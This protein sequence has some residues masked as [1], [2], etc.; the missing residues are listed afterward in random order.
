M[1]EALLL[2]AK[3]ALIDGELQQAQTYLTE[4]KTVATELNRSLL[5]ARVETE[6]TQLTTDFTKWTNLIRQNAPLQER[7]TEARL[8]EYLQKVQDFLVRMS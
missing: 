5:I 7:L 1:A 3:F 8:E 2:Q 6:Q 4:A